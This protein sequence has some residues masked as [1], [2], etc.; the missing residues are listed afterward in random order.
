MT[1]ESRFLCAAIEDGGLN[2]AGTLVTGFLLLIPG[3]G[4]LEQGAVAIVLPL[5][6][7]AVASAL[8]QGVVRKWRPSAS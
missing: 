8:S 7:F 6:R 3:A 2:R 1:G 4:K 5:D